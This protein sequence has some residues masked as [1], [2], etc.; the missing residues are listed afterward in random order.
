MSI[1]PIES[2]PKPLSHKAQGFFKPHVSF[3]AELLKKVK[4]SKET[5]LIPKG[6]L[7]NIA[8]ELKNNTVSEKEASEKF[9][10]M[11]LEKSLLGKE[12]NLNQLV[13]NTFISNPD[14][15]DNLIKNLKDLT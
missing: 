11:I 9:I 3:K 8:R 6:E 2:K 4:E 1:T 13:T 10:S 5:Q 15:N 12:E 14:F 7:A